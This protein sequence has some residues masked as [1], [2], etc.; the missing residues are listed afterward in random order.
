MGQLKT[1]I[2]ENTLIT[3][4]DQ[5]TDVEKAPTIKVRLLNDIF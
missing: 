1:K 2:D 5:M 3:Y 4:L